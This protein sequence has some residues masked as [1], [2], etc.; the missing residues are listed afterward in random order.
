MNYVQDFQS[1][2]FG[3]ESRTRFPKLNLWL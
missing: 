1:L 2:I 3:Y